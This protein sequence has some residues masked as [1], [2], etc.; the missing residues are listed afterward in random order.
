MISSTHTWQTGFI[1]GSQVKDAESFRMEIFFKFGFP[2]YGGL[3]LDALYDCPS[4]LNRHGISRHFKLSNNEELVILIVDTYNLIQSEF[5]LFN[6]FLEI[7]VDVDTGWKKSG[8]NTRI[9]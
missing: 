5:K 6:D 1:E 2:D 7:I 3:N 4:S 8:I 9:L